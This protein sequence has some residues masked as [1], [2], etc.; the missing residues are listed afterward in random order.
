MSGPVTRYRLVFTPNAG[1]TLPDTL[2]GDGFKVDGSAVF[3]VY[4]PA[5]PA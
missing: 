4:L 3:H 2:P 5:N 1:F